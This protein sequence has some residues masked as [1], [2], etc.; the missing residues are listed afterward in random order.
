MLDIQWITWESTD[1]FGKFKKNSDKKEKYLRDLL[2]LG[3]EV[4]H[5]D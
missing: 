3:Y 1:K 4:R 2:D 5:V